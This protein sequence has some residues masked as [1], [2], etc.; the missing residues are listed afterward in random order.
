MNPKK[1]LTT[2]ELR[3]FGIVMSVAL[4]IVSSFLLWRGGGWATWGYI[5]ASTFLMLGLI[6]PE[7]LREVER[8]W[9][10][11]AEFLGAIVTRVLLML[12][13]F[14]VITPIGLLVQLFSKDQFVK[15][16][17]RKASTYWVAIPS[18]KS[19]SRAD[20]PF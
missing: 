3:K 11:G 19:D 16:F 10:I 12:S 6:I 17:N 14:F 4:S 7:T 9:M 5:P 15:S 8:I 1:Q 20:Q 18:D 13:F 2:A